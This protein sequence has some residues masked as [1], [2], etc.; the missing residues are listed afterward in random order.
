LYLCS[1]NLFADPRLALDLLRV[2]L[3]LGQ[4]TNL[5]IPMQVSITKEKKRKEKRKEK[6]PVKA[7]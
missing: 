6:L 3:P 7:K 1:I 4:E 5:S 2:K